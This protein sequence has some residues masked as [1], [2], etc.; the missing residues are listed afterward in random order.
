LFITIDSVIVCGK[1]TGM[2]GYVI[3]I[4]GTHQVLYALVLI[5]VLRH[6]GKTLIMHAWYPGLPG[7]SWDFIPRLDRIWGHR[8][9]RPALLPF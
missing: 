8:A 5:R 9:E 6:T 2:V 3:W 1:I 7:F 4:E